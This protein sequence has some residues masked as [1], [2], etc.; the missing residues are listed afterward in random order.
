MVNTPEA[1][2]DFDVAVIGGGLMGSSIAWGLA[3][4][5]QRVAVL[6][7]GD[8]AYRASRGNFALIWVHSKGLGLAPYSAWTMRSSNAWTGFA[9]ALQ[10][11]T[12]IDVAFQRPGGFNLSLSAREFEARRDVLQRIQDQPGQ[13]RFDFEMV[14]RD[15]VKQAIPQIGP[16]V[17][18]ASYS[19]FDGHCNALRLYRALNAGMQQL[20]ATYLSDHRVERIEH[21]TGEFRMTTKRGEVRAAKIV[22]AAGIDNVRLAP[23]VGMNIPVRAQRGQLIVTEKTAPFLHYPVQTVRQTDE[24]GVM[25]GDSQEEA[26]AD[27]TVSSDVTAVLA[28]RAMRMF[29]QLA[30]LNIVR[31]WACLRVMT[32]D[33][34]PIYEQ[35]KTCPGA[36]NA[37]VHSGVTLAAAHALFLAPQI[38]A[39][40]LAADDFAPFSARRFDVQA[41]AA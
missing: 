3:Q 34:F 41:L 17:V 23:M 29:P 40:Q 39:G 36:F 21:V 4:N 19:R 11:Q 8:V 20:G 13:Q 6:D 25:M 33:G 27:P 16:E 12:G 30:S 9:D 2:R 31:T 10:Q 35:S 22:L 32:K 5:G 28:D 7:E 1:R 24:G 38:A 15:R 26:G 18:G 37:S 14:D